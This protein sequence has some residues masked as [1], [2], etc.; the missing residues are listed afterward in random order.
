MARQK[1]EKNNTISS[2][3]SEREKQIS[4]NFEKIGYL[5]DI[6]LWYPD[7]FLDMNTPEEGGIKLHF[8]Q[9]V[10]LRSIMRFYSI[11]GCFPRGYGKTFEEV[12]AQFLVAVRYPNMRLSL[13]AQT[14]ENAARLLGDKYSDIT[15]YYP[16]F[17]NE[18]AKVSIQKNDALIIFNNNS[19]IDSIAN[20]DSSKGLR[21][22]RLSIEESALIN[23]AVFEDSL[24]P[25][26]EIGRVTCGK[27]AVVNPEE[28]NQKIDFF[29]TP[30][31]RGSDEY[32][33]SI[34]MLKDMIDL[35]GSIVMGSDWMLPCWYGRGSSKQQII[36][37]KRDMSPI[38]FAM[39]YGGSWTGTST[40]ALVSPNKLMS[41][42]VLQE[43]V[44][45]SDDEADEF[46]IGVDVARSENKTNNQS[47]IAIG[48]VI[49][50]KDGKILE[51]QLCNMIHMSNTLNFATQ[52]CII[53]RTQK[54]Y[55]ARAVIVDAN[56]LGI[57][58][59]DELMKENYDAKTGETYDCWDTI[60]TE[61]KPEKDGAVK[62]IY[63][64]KAQSDQTRIIS[65]F[66]NMID[67]DKFHFLISK[68]D[69]GV[70]VKTEDDFDEK[71]M[72]FVQAELF[73]QEVCNLK[74]KQSGKNLQVEQVARKVDKDR[75]SA[76]SYL[77][78]YI[79]KY[80]GVFEDTKPKMSV[81]TFA[82]MM[83]QINKRPNI[84]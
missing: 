72:P 77:L 13:S 21:R 12:L 65:T 27:M 73:F 52:A 9:R 56:G 26:V 68:T 16:F 60:N 37:K 2:L 49:R 4:E 22:H 39:N 78:Y 40:G 63:A 66:I 41:C 76:V 18:I 11:Y 45:S 80:E 14:K 51:V 58:L 74:L 3:N 10:F 55:N 75:F 62:M 20:S 25:I 54:R 70:D 33:R 42:R 71:L 47:S 38:S 59:V 79:D 84:Y 28:L 46:Y 6:L 1:T 69:L 8:D 30:S 83:K 15:R 24:K 32:E 48:K 36:Q 29:T 67:A 44:L 57:G 35:R 61:A 34:G 17:N 5:A 31:F 43:P 23:N 19:Q 7:I 64:L 53:K 50:N 82:Q 81:K